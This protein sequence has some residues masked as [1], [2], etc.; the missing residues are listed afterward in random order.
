MVHGSSEAGLA[1]PTQFAFPYGSVDP[2]AKRLCSSRFEAARGVQNELNHGT[3]D[4]ALLKAVHLYEDTLTDDRLDA[5][6]KSAQD[7][8]AWLVFL[9]HGVCDHPGPFDTSPRQLARAVAAAKTNGL[10]MIT[11]S[12]ALRCFTASTR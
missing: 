5:L 7:Q 11:V 4:R 3:A 10:P 2:R 8:G 1:A 6:M 9:S 12:E